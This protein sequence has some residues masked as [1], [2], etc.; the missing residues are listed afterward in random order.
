MFVDRRP[1]HRLVCRPDTLVQS[2]NRNA[3]IDR[4]RIGPTPL[5][6]VTISEA[7]DAPMCLVR[8]VTE[9]AGLR[10][11][12][13]R[14]RITCGR[15]DCCYKWAFSWAVIGKSTGHTSRARLVKLDTMGH[16]PRIHRCC[17]VRMPDS[18][19][20]HIDHRRHHNH[21]HFDMPRMT[22]RHPRA[23]NGGASH[24]SRR[25][26]RRHKPDSC[27]QRIANCLPHNHHPQRTPH[28]GQH[29]CSHHKLDGLGGNPHQLDRQHRLSHRL[30]KPRPERNQHCCENHTQSTFPKRIRAYRHRNLHRGGT[31]HIGD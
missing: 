15:S 6:A 1:R 16:P 28:I 25:C 13:V 12:L 14:G 29:R 7:F 27:R 2:L 22:N 26:S 31:P 4:S 3:G 21:R 11:S 9:W 18:H 23:H 5:H 8:H 30:G 24:H 20:Q 19:P 17:R 10:T